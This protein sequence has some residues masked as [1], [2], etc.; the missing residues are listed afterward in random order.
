M[1]LGAF[2]YRLGDLFVNK[3]TIGR[4]A[5]EDAVRSFKDDL[6]RILMNSATPAISA[7]ANVRMTCQ[8][9]VEA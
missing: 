3:A 6:L 8:Y 7:E 9:T 1:L 2:D 5:F 4:V